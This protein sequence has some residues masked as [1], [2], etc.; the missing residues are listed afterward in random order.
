MAFRGFKLRFYPW[1]SRLRGD[2]AR[3]SKGK[4]VKGDAVVKFVGF[5]ERVEEG[6]AYIRIYPEFEAALKGVDQYSHLIILYW[7]HLRDT[8]EDRG[9]LTV[10]PRRH[11][12]APEVGVFGTRSPSRPNPI[13]LCV[14]KL[15]RVEGTTLKVR[16]LDAYEGTPIIDVKPYI[17]RADRKFMVKTPGWVKHGPKT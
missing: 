2:G 6:W 11:R 8:V 16:D 5:V 1:P 10:I 4:A 12:G 9:T 3:P 14:V 7:M 13:G 15:E 17:P